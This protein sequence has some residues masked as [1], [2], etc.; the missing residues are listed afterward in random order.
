M[1]P[2]RVSIIWLLLLAV[3]VSLQSQGPEK[4]ESAVVR[5]LALIDGVRS[6][7]TGFVVDKRSN[8]AYVLTAGHVVAGDKHP[9]IEIYNHRDELVSAEVIRLDVSNDLALLAIRDTAKVSSLH[10]VAFGTSQDLKKGDQLTAIGFPESGGAWS[11]TKPVFAA[12]EGAELTVSGGVNSG[13]SGG[14]L[15]S[16]GIVVGIVNRLDKEFARAVPS[17]V[18]ILVLRGWEIDVIEHSQGEIGEEVA[19]LPPLAEQVSEPDVESTSRQTQEKP[20]VSTNKK[21]VDIVKLG[22]VGTFSR[23]TES[24]MWLS[25]Q[26]RDGV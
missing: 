9:L 1:N 5:I 16:D 23:G 15:L 4:T 6:V 11:I 7:G 26:V 18:A 22:Y 17:D 8:T 25:A 3:S 24:E 12:R 14:P 10:R 19:P 2:N 21:K 13:S 20:Q